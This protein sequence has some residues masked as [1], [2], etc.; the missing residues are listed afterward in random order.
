MGFVCVCG[1]G[2]VVFVWGFFSV[3][4]V[5][6]FPLVSQLLLYMCVR[7]RAQMVMN[8]CAKADVEF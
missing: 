8:M 1:G 2:G 6:F 4:F 5:S 3:V 7:V